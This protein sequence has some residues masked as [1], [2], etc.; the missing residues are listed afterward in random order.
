VN[1]GCSEQPALEIRN[2]HVIDVRTGRVSFDATLVMDDGRI[3]RIA[4]GSEQSSARQYIDGR[5]RYALPGLWLDS[6]EPAE[7][8]QRVGYGITHVHSGTAALE[9]D[10]ALLPD[11]LAQ[12][13]R[14]GWSPL[15]ALQSVTLQA[16]HRA[17]AGRAGQLAAGFDADVVL[18]EANPLEDITNLRRISLVVWQGEPVGLVQLAR[19][20]AGRAYTRQPS[21]P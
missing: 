11:A 2:V 14:D 9:S 3:C 19:A 7:L 5:G 20:R 16:A 21:A 1:R 8:F 17:R 10:P 12:R 13:V 15:Q 4:S 18:L 6:A